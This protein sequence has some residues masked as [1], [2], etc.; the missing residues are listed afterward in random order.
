MVIMIS[1]DESVCRVS[2]EHTGRSQVFNASDYFYKKELQT[3]IRF[4]HCNR[5]TIVIMNVPEKPMIDFHSGID[6]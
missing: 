1:P 4:F 5:D 3:G 6:Q 2:G